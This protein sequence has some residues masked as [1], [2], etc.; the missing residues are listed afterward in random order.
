MP[1]AARLTW[2]PHAQLRLRQRGI[3]ITEVKAVVANAGT[4]VKSVYS[5]R[6]RVLTA[7]V[8][9]P[10]RGITVVVTPFP[11]ST[12]VVTAWRAKR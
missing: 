4:D 5:A 7:Q 1:Y 8:G 3:T 12:R 11:K 6:R 2:S 10:P 9:T